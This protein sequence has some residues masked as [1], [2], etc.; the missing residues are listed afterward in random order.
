[1]TSIGD[2]DQRVDRPSGREP[3][4]ARAAT[5]LC[6]RPRDRKSGAQCRVAR[7]LSHRAD[8][9]AV[10]GHFS[11]SRARSARVDVNVHPAKREV[12][13]RDPDGVREAVVEAIRARSK[14]GAAIGSENFARRLIRRDDRSR[15]REISSIQDSP[16]AACHSSRR[17]PAICGTVKRPSA[18]NVDTAAVALSRGTDSAAANDHASPLQPVKSRRQRDQQFQIIGVLNKLYVLMENAD[19]LVL[20]DQ[21]AAHERILFE[22]LRRRMEE[23]GVPSQRL[24]L[25]QTFDLPPRDAEWVERNMSRS[26]KKWESAS[27]VSDRTHS[28]ST[29]CRRF[30][31]SSDAGQFH[32]RSD[33]RFEKREQQQFAAAPRRRHDREDGLPSRGQSER[34]AALS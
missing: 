14:A 27:R 5:R 16:P 10:S 17:R 15:R 31:T 33:R 19:G 7:G 30:S 12:R 18:R 23:Q 26:C 4:D 21:H 34:S 32:A 9:R 20:V 6:E 3:A 28:R 2:R 11:F 22:E 25:P 29:A 13:F 1:M 24:L 8:E